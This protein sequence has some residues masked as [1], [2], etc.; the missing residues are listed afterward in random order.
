MV[1]GTESS[2]RI[3]MITGRCS[4]DRIGSQEHFKAGVQFKAG[5]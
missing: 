5:C 1:T 4:C 2:G 3:F